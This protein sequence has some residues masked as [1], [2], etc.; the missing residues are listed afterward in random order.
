MKSRTFQTVVLVFRPDA[1]YVATATLVILHPGLTSRCAII[2]HPSALILILVTL[3]HRN[4]YLPR[5]VVRAKLVGTK[6]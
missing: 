3:A 2:L 6:T 5:L 4:G 1:P